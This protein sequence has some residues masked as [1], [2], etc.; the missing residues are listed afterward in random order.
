MWVIIA[1][2]I[3]IVLIA[4]YFVIAYFA[5][6]PPF[7]QKSDASDNS[8]DDNGG[9]NDG[10]SSNNGNFAIYQGQ[11]YQTSFSTVV[12]SEI[13]ANYIATVANVDQCRQ[14]CES[15]VSCRNFGTL[16][17]D[18]GE[19]YCYTSDLDQNY[20]IREGAI[21]GVKKSTS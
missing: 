5:G 10:G 15:N 7:S 1:F 18:G 21:I 11:F 12:R 2:V 4:L 9:S 19:Y 13:Y 17:G 3:L 6:L 16:P 14:L 8:S 20:V